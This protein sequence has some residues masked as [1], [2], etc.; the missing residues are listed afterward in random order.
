MSAAIRLYVSDGV[1][2]PQRKRRSKLPD[3]LRTE[4]WERLVVAATSEVLDAKIASK[5][6]A[7]CRDEIA[8]HIG[9]YSG[10][11][12]SEICNLD[13]RHLDFSRRQLFVFEGKGLKDRYVAMPT[14]LI[15]RLSKWVE[16]K[17][18][19]IL[20]SATGE[21]LCRRTLCWRISR[22]GRIAK[23]SKHLHCHMLRHAYAVRLL[24]RGVDIKQ[25]QQLLG[26]NSLTST[27]V[28]LHCDTSRL[29]ESVELL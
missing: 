21:R 23:L 9:L 15:E 25:I 22:L 14:K 7:A 26:H 29:Q 5:H 1:D 12:I 19:P 6:R 8:V 3:F 24:E 13:V 2:S 20:T 17:S 18:G 16:G 10:L 27:A 11:R 4:D 28:Y